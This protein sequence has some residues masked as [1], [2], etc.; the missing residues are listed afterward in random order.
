MTEDQFRAHVAETAPHLLDTLAPVSRARGATKL[1]GMTPDAFLAQTDEEFLARVKEE[2]A[3]F[4]RV[5]ATLSALMMAEQEFEE[6]L[7][8]LVRARERKRRVEWDALDARINKR[9]AERDAQAESAEPDPTESEQHETDTEHGEDG[10][11]N[12]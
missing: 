7:D 4:T 10:P 6:A 9:I 2:A 3:D 11:R 8:I 1:S 5:R 12:S